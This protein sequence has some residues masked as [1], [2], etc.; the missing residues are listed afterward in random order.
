[1]TLKLSPQQ[2]KVAYFFVENAASDS[3]IA[4]V[5]GIDK[6]TVSLHFNRMK[7]S[8]YRQTHI[9]IKNRVHLALVLTREKFELQEI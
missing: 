2:Y 7:R 6:A 1:M 4:Q 9:E 8:I 3:E 5:M